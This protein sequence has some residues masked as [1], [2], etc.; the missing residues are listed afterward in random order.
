MFSHMT[1]IFALFDQGTI[2]VQACDC[3]DT[4]S[5]F[6]TVSR[7]AKKII[8]SRF[9]SSYQRGT[10]IQGGEQDNGYFGKLRRSADATTHFVTIHTWHH[11]IQENKV[12]LKLFKHMK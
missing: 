1:Y 5:Q 3:A 4:G 2:T 6:T 11:H 9:N 12:R 10:I 8:G 7:F